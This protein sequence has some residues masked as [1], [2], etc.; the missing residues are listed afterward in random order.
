MESRPLIFLPTNIDARSAKKEDRRSKK[1]QRTFDPARCLAISTDN[2]RTRQGWPSSEHDW[3]SRMRQRFLVAGSTRLF[4]TA[5]LDRATTR[6][7]SESRHTQRTRSDLEA[8]WNRRSHVGRLG[9]AIQ[10]VL[11][12]ERSCR[13]ATKPEGIGSE[14]QSQICKRPAVLSRLLRHWLSERVHDQAGYELGIEIS[15]LGRHSFLM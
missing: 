3:R 14:K 9:L 6:H 12:Q 13:L 7:C 10:E 11:R 4:N 15:A 2:Q 1:T 8:N 5:R